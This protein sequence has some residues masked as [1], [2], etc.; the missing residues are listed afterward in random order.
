MA[1]KKVNYNHEITIIRKELEESGLQKGFTHEETIHISKKLDTI[2]TQCIKQQV[3][4]EKC[5]VKN[6]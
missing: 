1:D 2:I 3:K 4:L 5:D 6:P